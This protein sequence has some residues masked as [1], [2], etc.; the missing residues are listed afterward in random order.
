MKNLYVILGARPQFIK[1]APLSKKI[2]ELK[3]LKEIIIHT[4]QHY[5]NNMSDIFFNQLNIKSPDINLNI[6]NVSRGE[7]IGLMIQKI[8]DQFLK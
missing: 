5:D 2:Q 1:Y 4:G 3:N 8:N 6:N 7:M